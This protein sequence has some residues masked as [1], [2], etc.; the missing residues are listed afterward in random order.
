MYKNLT[1]HE[2][3]MVSFLIVEIEE[4]NKCIEI[5]QN[6]VNDRDPFN[7]NYS[8]T[9]LERWTQEAAKSTEQLEVFKRLDT[10]RNKSTSLTL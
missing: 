6:E 5:Y 2:A 7:L 3:N 8:Q 4:A 9:M 1:K 10:E